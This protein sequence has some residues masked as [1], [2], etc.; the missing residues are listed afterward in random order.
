MLDIKRSK[1]S[2][3]F[4][5]LNTPTT[6]RMDSGNE[7]FIFRTG[8][9]ISVNLATDDLFT[10]NTK[11][12]YNDSNFV[13]TIVCIE[14]LR[15]SSIRNS[16]F[17]L[18]PYD[19]FQMESIGLDKT[20]IV[21]KNRNLIDISVGDNIIPTREDLNTRFV[22]SFIHNVGMVARYAHP[23]INKSYKRVSRLDWE[24]LSLVP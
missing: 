7:V 15:I 6:V 23:N 12:F 21:V 22:Y 3:K 10:G 5:I 4:T 19:S 2:P 8:A 17:T 18:H 13:H 11:T 1:I 9:S 20:Y 14:E 16:T 24:E